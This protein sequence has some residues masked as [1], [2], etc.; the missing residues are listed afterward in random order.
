MLKVNKK[1]FKVLFS[2]LYDFFY[3]LIVICKMY[4]VNVY[5]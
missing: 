1:K 4:F 5:S 3:I 2:F